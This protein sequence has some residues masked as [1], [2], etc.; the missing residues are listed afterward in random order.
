MN[1]GVWLPSPDH[2]VRALQDLSSNLEKKVI[3]K[4]NEIATLKETIRHRDDQLSN[5]QQELEDSRITISC[6]ES[7]CELKSERILHLSNLIE[8]RKPTEPWRGK[9]KDDK[10]SLRSQLETSEIKLER[11]RIHCDSLE[12][13][14]IS[15]EERLRESDK[16]LCRLQEE[17]GKSNKLIRDLSDIVRSLNCV[18]ISYEKEAVEVAET[19]ALAHE[20]AIYPKE[21]TFRVCCA[22]ILLQF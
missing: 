13:E 9:Q 10:E 12:K 4:E 2:R 14:N 20:V 15:L 16:T 3:V 5:L 8:N 11:I 21:N 7:K 22:S 17:R 1:N 6:L 19:T 18:T